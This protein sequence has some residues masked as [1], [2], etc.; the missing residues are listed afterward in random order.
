MPI[1]GPEYGAGE[2]KSADRTLGEVLLAPHRSY[3]PLLGELLSRKP[4]IIKALAHIT[5]GGFIENLPRILPPGVDAVVRRGSWPVPALY[6]LIRRLGSIAD[7][8]MYRVF[9][10]G[11]GMVAVVA[12][13]RLAELTS[14]IPETCWVIG[15]LERGA[16]AGIARME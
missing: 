13:E 14:S 8:E 7:E 4:R 11:I 12:P 6:G 16:S 5:G 10:M 1:L 9:N 3:L 2:W 15:K